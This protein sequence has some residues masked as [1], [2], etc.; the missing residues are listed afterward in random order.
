MLSD[1][2]QDLR[3]FPAVS[4]LKHADGSAVPSAADGVFTAFKPTVEK[5]SIAAPTITK[6]RAAGPARNVS[7]GG[8]PAREP[9][10]EEW[11]QAEVYNLTLT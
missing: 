10:M 1:T 3:M 4:G 11:H 8:R 5:V 7:Q 6:V 2:P 9:T